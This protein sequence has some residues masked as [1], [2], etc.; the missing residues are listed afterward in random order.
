MDDGP[1]EKG[2]GGL[3]DLDGR[4]RRIPI[5]TPT[6]AR[7]APRSKTPVPPSLR[8]SPAESVGKEVLRERS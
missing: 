2:T 4:H 5:P 8:Q 1:L 6:P 3:R 7:D